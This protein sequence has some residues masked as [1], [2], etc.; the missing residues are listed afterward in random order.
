MDKMNS[1]LEELK[2]K[3]TS[4]TIE[5]VDYLFTANKSKTVGLFSLI[6]RKENSINY[7]QPVGLKEFKDVADVFANKL[8]V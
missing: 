7:D 2:K 8:V 3:T 5:D 1:T 4:V 6:F